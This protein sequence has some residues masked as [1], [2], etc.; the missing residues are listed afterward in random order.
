VS[1]VH[2][3]PARPADA[4]V[5][6]ALVQRAYAHYVPRVGR[7]PGPM[8]AD[9]AQRIRA[10]AVVVAADEDEDEDEETVGVLVMV[11]GEDHL[12]IE[13][14]AVAH[15]RQRQG[16][17]RRLLDHAEHRAAAAGLEEIRLYTHV[18]MTENRAWYAN[19]GYVET[20]TI[21]TQSFERVSLVK[22]LG[23]GV[24]FRATGPDDIDAIDR[25]VQA[26]F[27]SYAA[28]AGPGWTAPR[29]QTERART[30]A[31]LAAP[32]TW[33]LI[34]DGPRGPAGHVAFCP[35]RQRVAADSGMGWRTRPL[36]P[37][38]AHLW[39]LFI[40]PEWWGTTI[41]DQLHQRAR[42][43]MVARRMTRARLYTP[44]RHVRARRFYERRGW[45]AGDEAYNED[46]RLDLTEYRLELD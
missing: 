4:P 33:A 26:G 35:G 1:R 45:R 17:G 34:A 27:D 2:L 36:I 44:A 23:P 28:F 14:V 5:L 13:N 43:A 31:L 15:H 30:M 8:N 18:M 11:L 21:R 46:L 7:R 25:H 32:E 19:L 22:R 24:S 20:G 9:Y 10:C 29:V 39:Q 42:E 40:L 38:L 6:T 3:R 41:A 12:L 16:L 37:G